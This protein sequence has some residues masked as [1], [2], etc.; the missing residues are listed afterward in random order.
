M[1]QITYKDEILEYVDGRDDINIFQ[2]LGDLSQHARGRSIRKTI[3]GKILSDF[4]VLQRAGLIRR[5]R[6]KKAYNV[7]EK[8]CSGIHELVQDKWKN[9]TKHTGPSPL[10]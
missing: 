6:K 10:L 1:I 2:L 3:R 5:R 9:C 8:T 7:V 4:H